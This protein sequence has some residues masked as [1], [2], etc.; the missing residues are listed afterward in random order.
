M[1]E[2]NNNLQLATVLRTLI[3][4]VLLCLSYDVIRGA[5]KAVDFSDFAVFLQ[6]VIFCIICAP[7][8]FIFLLATTNGELRGFVFVGMVAGFVVARLTVSRIFVL[9]FKQITFL[10]SK[11]LNIVGYAQSCVVCFLEGFF[12]S[13]YKKSVNFSK[14]AL[15][16]LK[17]LLKKQ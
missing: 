7:V 8:T 17:K 5:R 1:W 12:S 10:I 9:I 4:G 11:L 14:K 3:L 6:D 16:S 13:F 15:N 2:I